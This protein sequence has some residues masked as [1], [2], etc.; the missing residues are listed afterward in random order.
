M[1]H[2]LDHPARV[3][4]REP[5]PAG[6]VRVNP[7]GARNPERTTARLAA[8][9]RHLWAGDKDYEADFHLYDKKIPVILYDKKIP[10]ITTTLAGLREHG[11]HGQLFR[12]FGRSGPQTLFDAI[13]NP[14]RQAAL[15]RHHEVV[16][17]AAAG[18]GIRK[19]KVRGQ[20]G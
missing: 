4:A 3:R 12:R 7:L 10:V 1:A 13:G 8:L 16:R 14:R 5:V 9:T 2:P 6:A 11:P 19:P 20:T 17:T 15:E 18:A